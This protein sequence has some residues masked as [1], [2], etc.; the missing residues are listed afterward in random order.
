MTLYSG[1]ESSVWLGGKAP[2]SHSVNWASRQYQV[3]PVWGEVSHLL[4]GSTSSYQGLSVQTFFFVFCSFLFACFYLCDFREGVP[5]CIFIARPLN[6]EDCMSSSLFCEETVVPSWFW[7]P[8]SHIWPQLQLGM[9][10][11]MISLAAQEGWTH[12]LFPVVLCV[13]LFSLWHLCFL[14]GVSVHSF[15]FIQR[16]GLK[17]FL[18]KGVLQILENASRKCL[19]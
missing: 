4:N 13:C 3:F 1:L 18:L 9:G 10:F 17:R 19:R 6:Q 5:C 11:V 8:P 7:I 2:L 14:V 15:S 16:V 12:V